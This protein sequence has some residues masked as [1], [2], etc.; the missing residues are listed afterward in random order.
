M[1]IFI[2][3][4]VENYIKVQN[5]HDNL[6]IIEKTSFRNIRLCE[7]KQYFRFYFK[8]KYVNNL[9]ITKNF[10]TQLLNDNLKFA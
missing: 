5:N 2:K 1:N 10:I 3:D 8:T 9:N 4:E 7:A 6:I